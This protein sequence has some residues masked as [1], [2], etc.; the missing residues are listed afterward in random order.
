M[1]EIQNRIAFAIDRTRKVIPGYFEKTLA[2]RA[3]LSG[4]AAGSIYEGVGETELE[5]MLRG[6]NWE[7]YSHE[8]VMPGCVAYKAAISGSLGIIDLQSMASDAVVRLDDRKGTGQVSCVVTGARG[9]IVPFTVL[10]LGQEQGEEV[11]FTFHP[12]DPVRPSQIRTESGMHGR[13]VTVSEALA[14]GLETAKAE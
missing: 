13:Q 9:Q 11:I 10:I 12:G 2:Q 4:K 6:A 3:E 8:A 7:E 5:Q 14:M 1:N